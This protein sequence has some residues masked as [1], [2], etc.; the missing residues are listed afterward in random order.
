MSQARKAQ[1]LNSSRMAGM[2]ASTSAMV[3]WK[4]SSS[5]YHGSAVSTRYSAPFAFSGA[6]HELVIQ[7]V[8][9]PT[10]DS[11]AAESAAE[12]ARQ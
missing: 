9:P 7:L 2:A 3:S 4:P 6:L 12:M 11:A 1:A 10:T 8:S 5:P